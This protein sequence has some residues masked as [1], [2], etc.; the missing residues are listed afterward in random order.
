MIYKLMPDARTHTNVHNA[1]HVVQPGTAARESGPQEQRHYDS[2]T[3]QS[4]GYS[5]KDGDE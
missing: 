3:T 1:G 4:V 5:P 2:A